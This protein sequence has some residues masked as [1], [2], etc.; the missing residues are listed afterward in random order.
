M[1]YATT[2]KPI[3]YAKTQNLADGNANIVRQDSDID[4][5]SYHYLYETDNGI[6]AEETGSVDPST[7]VGGT[8]AR[9]FFEYI[10]DDGIRYRV[11]YVADENGFQPSGA[12]LP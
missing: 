1:I 11:D 4:I 3:I 7:N 5:N 6:A 10:G 8:K 12:H 9:G 2:P